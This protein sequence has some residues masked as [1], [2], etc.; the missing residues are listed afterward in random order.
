MLLRSRTLRVAGVLGALASAGMVA[1]LVL[2]QLRSTRA[3]YTASRTHL[4]DELGGVLA[5]A[6]G[7]G[8]TEH[9][10]ALLGGWAAPREGVASITVESTDGCVLTAWHAAQQSYV[11]AEPLELSMLK[12]G[13][14]WGR[15]QLRTFM[16]S[17]RLTRMIA[18][19]SEWP[20]L[21]ACAAGIASC[22]IAALLKRRRRRGM[23]GAWAAARE[24]VQTTL[25]FLA[26]GVVVLDHRNNIVFANRPLLSLLGKDIGEVRGASVDSLPWRLR[27]EHFGSPTEAWW[28]TDSRRVSLALACVG[29]VDRALVAVCA[30]I[31]Q[32][33]RRYGTLVTLGDVTELEQSRT[34]LRGARDAADRANDAKGVFL[35]NMSHEIR[36]PINGV[37]GTLELL[38]ETTLET[39]QR[40][41]LDGAQVSASTLLHLINDILDLSKIEAGKLELHNTDFNLEECLATGLGVVAEGAAGKGL[42]L[43]LNIAAEVERLAVGDGER[44]RQV[45][46]NL[47]SNAVKFTERGGV[48]VSVCVAEESTEQQLLRIE[49]TD[50][51]IGIPQ[52]RID[53]LFK[54]FSQVDSS[55]SRRFGGTGLGLHIS[56]QLCELMGGYVEAES[57]VGQGSTFRAYVRLGRSGGT[58]EPEPTIVLAA[59][60]RLVGR[61]CVV[62]D[63]NDKSRTSL[64]A[65][66]ERF[67][68]L[69]CECPADAPAMADALARCGSKEPIVLIGGVRWSDAEGILARA[70]R[71]QVPGATVIGIALSEP[72]PA[73]EESER[74]VIDAWVRKP[75]TARRFADAIVVATGDAAST[76][77]GRSPAVG[78]EIRKDVRVL[79]AEDHP[80]GQ[81]ITREAVTAAGFEC[82]IAATG[83]EA[84]E[85]AAS[86]CFGIVLM[87]C[88]LPDMDGFEVTRRLRQLE[89]SSRDS[90]RMR[91]IALTANA[92]SGDRERCLGAGMD[93]YLSKPIARADLMRALAEQSQLA[94]A[95]ASRSALE[96]AQ[97]SNSAEQSAID[98][99]TLNDR[100][101]RQQ[102]LMSQLLQ[103]F[104][105]TTADDLAKIEH[106]LAAQDSTR[107][108]ES[109]HR[110]AGSAFQV[111]ALNLG[112]LARRLENEA[113]NDAEASLQHLRTEFARCVNEI[114]DIDAKS[115]DSPGPSRH[116]PSQRGALQME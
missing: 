80:I 97:P 109:A 60:K 96:S 90:T 51:G 102:D 18:G 4:A 99:E 48:S 98:F 55:T 78:L 22:G 41:Y 7:R 19:L 12:D 88:H 26:E 113:T 107:I 75:L 106:A 34:E 16:P 101:L 81:M 28:K 17:D 8:G 15:A 25:D 89:S 95:S 69:V 37:M 71:G 84:F 40:R 112:N 61:A 44:L 62:C 54:S 46:L 116:P 83:P 57:T 2:N 38:G 1:L 3:M 31:Q 27:S 20:A 85:A 64:R 87:D 49:V 29:G 10:P 72:T 50:T 43:T 94:P 33:T 23:G 93:G 73:I 68:M 114:R 74:G 111:G 110:I 115:T 42:E 30:P 47:V 76:S 53:R 103:L 39:S 5:K 77:A 82:E 14:P 35:A 21:T 86:G 24:R 91:I 36:T 32:G 6:V 105:E 65:L 70:A 52:D 13:V 100:C 45:L 59:G 63:G 67:D 66:A 56:R 79:I 104:A 108:V 9:L 58:R 92:M 11:D